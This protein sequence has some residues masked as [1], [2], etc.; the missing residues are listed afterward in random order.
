MIDPIDT[1]YQ[2]SIIY[3]PLRQTD[4]MLREP[5]RPQGIT[6][7]LPQQPEMPGSATDSTR[8]INRYRSAQEEPAQEDALPRE[9]K[10]LGKNPSRLLVVEPDAQTTR[11]RFADPEAV[12]PQGLFA[13]EALKSD[14]PAAERSQSI[15]QEDAA[16]VAA[17]EPDRAVTF[18]FVSSDFS[19]ERIEN[20][21]PEFASSKNRSQDIAAYLNRPADPS[22]FDHA[23]ITSGRIDL[24]EAR[25][26]DN[27]L[28]ANDLE[29]PIDNLDNPFREFTVE[30]YGPGEFAEFRVFE[31]RGQP[32]PTERTGD[33]DFSERLTNNETTEA[34]AQFG[35]D[36][37]ALVNPQY[38]DTAVQQERAEFNA[39]NEGQTLV[40][41]EAQPQSSAERLPETVTV[42]T[43]PSNPL[44]GTNSNPNAVSVET[45]TTGYRDLEAPEVR[46][47]RVI[48]AILGTPENLAERIRVMDTLPLE[49]DDIFGLDSFERAKLLGHPADIVNRLGTYAPDVG[50][51]FYG[52]QM[53][54]IDKPREVQ[55]QP[56]YELAPHQKVER[57]EED[58]QEVRRDYEE[59]VTYTYNEISTAQDFLNAV[60]P[61]VGTNFF[62]FA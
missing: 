14:I 7:D 61:N 1:S 47:P 12:E 56:T 9:P 36:Q 59:R 46:R 29:T 60:T 62:F 19:Q 5:N 37:E 26:L 55:T 3:G 50:Q 41:S 27:P 58:A 13:F 20:P 11:A 22:N 44:S 18:E 33:N 30:P 21:T 8:Q 24:L 32:D 53:E 38:Q 2:Q 23:V 15:R 28:P 52:A 25:E 17:S 6:V 35:R 31:E 51:T 54:T 48:Q 16:T 45:A 49:A 34:V 40:P 4:L 39:R 57:N 42:T 10:E 43:P